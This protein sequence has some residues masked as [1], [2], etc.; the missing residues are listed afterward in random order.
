MEDQIKAGLAGWAKEQREQKQVD[1]QQIV[2]G[3]GKTVAP[4]PP[5]EESKPV[6]QDPPKEQ[7]PK[8]DEIPDK[9]EPPKS[10]DADEEDVKPQTQSI[11]D[12]SKTGSALGWNVKD[13][14]EF[15]AQASKLNSE[16]EELRKNPLKDVPED[17][18]EVL[19]IAKKSPENWKEY[20][21]SQIIN[22]NNVNPV[23]LYEEDF[24]DA[25]RKDL[26]FQRDGKFDVEAAEEFLA[27]QPENMKYVWGQQLKRVKM[28]EQ[29]NR[30]IEIRNK[31]EARIASAEKELSK[32]TQDLNEILPFDKYGIKFEAKNS[33]KIYKGIQD[34]SLTKKHLGVSYDDLVKSDAD[35]KMIT[36]TIT[37]AEEGEKMIKFKSENATARAKKDILDKVQN[38]QIN[39]PGSAIQIEDPKAK[40]L[41]AAEKMAIYVEQQKKKNQF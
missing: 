16:I 24:L 32:A 5:E 25:A 36:R 27:G 31:A 38:A 14:S 19:E 10:W 39:Q 22:Y 11:F 20:L 30:Q 4:E 29:R 3:D 2:P 37:L 8:T 12:F 15:V 7:E 41:T 6:A 23:N 28:D 17:F 33:I 9:V 13:E 34:S 26:R 18:K 35:M 40:V 1:N 21:A